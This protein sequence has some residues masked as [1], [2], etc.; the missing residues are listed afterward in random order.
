MHSKMLQNEQFKNQ[1]K[2]LVIW[3]VKKALIKLQK[4]QTLRNRIIHKQLQM[5]MTKKYSKK[6]IYIYIYIYI[7]I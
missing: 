6:N 7:Y 2:Q 4:Y 5:N 3:L 1:Q